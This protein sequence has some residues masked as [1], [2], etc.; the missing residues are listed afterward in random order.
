MKLRLVASNGVILDE[1]LIPK[2]TQ[3][4]LEID[5]IIILNPKYSR[6]MLCVLSDSYV[7]LVLLDLRKHNNIS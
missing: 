6:E 3:K 5:E 7:T 4:D 2:K 1:T